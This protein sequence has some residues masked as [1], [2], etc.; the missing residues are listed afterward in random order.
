M[1]LVILMHTDKWVLVSIWVVNLYFCKFVYP[2]GF[3]LQ[4]AVFVVLSLTPEAL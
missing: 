3:D 1:L 4:H 2:Y